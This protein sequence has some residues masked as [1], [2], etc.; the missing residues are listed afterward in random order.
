TD[1]NDKNKD[2]PGSAARG[3]CH[4]IG[5]EKLQENCP[6]SCGLCDCRDFAPKDK[7]IDDEQ[8]RLTVQF[9]FLIT[10]EALC[11][12]SKI[13]NDLK[14]GAGKLYCNISTNPYPRW[15]EPPIISLE[16]W[17]A[18]NGKKNSTSNP[19]TRKNKGDKKTRSGDDKK[20]KK[21]NI[22]CS[23]TNDS[24]KRKKVGRHKIDK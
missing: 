17:S 11:E 10:P 24:S 20:K 21:D 22:F 6:L 18:G 7:N 15:N 16:S 4:S 9:T 12:P 5:G 8:T 19:N 14:W 23:S 13:E 1:C 3:L 2:C